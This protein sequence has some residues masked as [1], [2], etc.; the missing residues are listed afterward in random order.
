MFGLRFKWF[1]LL[2]FGLLPVLT[3]SAQQVLTIHGVVSKGQTTERVAQALIK[4]L[5]SGDII[6]SDELGWFTVKA[7]P[8]DTLLFS[9][10]EFT[11]QKVVIQNGRD[12][13]VYM[14]PAVQLSTV[15]VKGQSTKQELNEVMKGYK[16]DG[17]FNNGNSLPVWQFINSPLTGLYNLFGSEP[18]KARRFARYAHD[19]REYAAI[20]RR[21]T[22]AF[23]KHVT[24]A[25]DTEVAKFMEYYMPTYE[26]IKAW[27]D[28]DLAKQVKKHFDY[29]EANKTRIKQSDEDMPLLNPNGRPK[30]KVDTAGNNGKP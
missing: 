8:G 20:T 17:V 11:P 13:P 18:A 15:T 29:F 4:N 10:D 25:P 5:R 2:A 26:D 23:V 6:M 7:E 12:L 16:Q 14:Q 27:N 30:M 19:E 28:Y 24:A 9:K 21:Y 3:A 22:P 1:I